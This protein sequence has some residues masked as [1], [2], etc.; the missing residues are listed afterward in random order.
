MYSQ[1][2]IRLR[3]RLWLPVSLYVWHPHG[4]SLSLSLSLSF[5]L[6]RTHL[7]WYARPRKYVLALYTRTIVWVYYVDVRGQRETL[8]SLS[9]H[10]FT[11][12]LRAVAVVVVVRPQT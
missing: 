3:V 11:V 7:C 4:T 10:T 5:S 1:T 8:L 12:V 2:Y 6:Y 9:S